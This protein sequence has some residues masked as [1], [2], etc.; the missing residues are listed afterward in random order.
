VRV[1]RVKSQGKKNG[2]SQKCKKSEKLMEER[3]SER[4]CENEKS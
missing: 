1:K 3:K 4:S 2:E